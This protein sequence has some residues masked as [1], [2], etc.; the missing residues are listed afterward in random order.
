M[1]KNIAVM[2]LLILTAPL[3]V[4]AQEN[5][6][7][8][9]STE[10][11][12]PKDPK[13]LAKLE[14]WQD[15]KFGMIIHWGL[16]A[17][18]GMVESW[19]LTSEDWINRKDSMTYCE[20]KEWYWGLSNEFNPVN[21]APEKWAETAKAAGMKYVVFTTKHHDGFNMFDTQQTDFKITNGPF[22][23]H[24]K[25]NVAKYVFEAF[26][27]EGMMIGAYY[28]KPDWHSQ[29]FWWDKYGSWDRNVNYNLAAHPERW[30]KFKQ[31]AYNQVEELTSD[32]G[33]ID[34]LWLDG[35]WVRPGRMVRNG[36]QSIDLPKIAAMAREHQ[37][38]LLVVDRTVHGPYE[39]YQTP[40]RSIPDHQIS[41][42]WESCIPLAN[43][44]G[45]V[46]NDE[47]KSSTKIIHSL[48]EI[49]AKG[50]SLLLGIGPKP[51]GTLREED[52]TRMKQI[53]A[54]LDQNGKAIYN[55]RITPE[56]NYENVFFTEGKEGEKYAIVNIP[57]SEKV[58][59]TVIWKGNT[60]KKGSKI[61]M[62]SNGKKVNW[63]LNKG[64]VEISI[65]EKF[66]SNNDTY[67]ALAF[68]F[69]TGN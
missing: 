47:L 42:P 67:P 3:F 16:Y 61:K 36:E 18:A 62:L 45:Y 9:M 15:Q 48:V 65:P 8:G 4:R 68:E 39:N 69:I 2:L 30:N 29:Y 5:N 1:S 43:N 13:V 51:D 10:Y 64:K 40:E 32:Y 41:N 6:L 31:F 11:D 60:P 20:F 23:N 25:A 26:R 50:G 55:T 24:P 7:H 46:P 38:G 17:Q 22:A 37:P 49:V 19:E 44:W 58:P 33:S 35:G 28:S 63:K 66:I 56:Y 53:G 27:N 21:F 54:W 12:W 34:I 59:S 14:K 57:E 52:V